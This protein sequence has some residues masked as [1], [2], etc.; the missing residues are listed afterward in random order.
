MKHTFNIIRFILRNGLYKISKAS[1][2]FPLNSPERHLPTRPQIA[3]SS[4]Q[5]FF[6][7]QSPV[8]TRHTM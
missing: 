5:Y 7:F 6:S 3:D 8:G 4:R 1:F 2:R